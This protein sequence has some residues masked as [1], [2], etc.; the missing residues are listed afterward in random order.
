[1]QNIFKNS[2]L[3]PNEIYDLFYD[4]I[5]L[6]RQNYLFLHKKADKYCSQ[7]IPKYPDPDDFRSGFFILADKEIIIDCELL[8]YYSDSFKKETFYK[9]HPPLH[10]DFG[11]RVDSCIEKIM[12]L[13]KSSL[14]RLMSIMEYSVREIILNSESELAT[15]V[16]RRDKLCDSFDNVYSKLE[17]DEQKPWKKFKQEV[18]SLPPFDSIAKIAEK[19]FSLGLIKKESFEIWKVL[20]TLRNSIVHNNA[21]LDTKLNS[22]KISKLVDKE[23][24]NF[25]QLELILEPGQGIQTDGFSSLLLLIFL[26]LDLFKE[27]L[28]NFEKMSKKL[29]VS[30]LNQDTVDN[31]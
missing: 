6:T 8:A 19:S 2:K 22:Q 18:K 9:A 25:Q 29:E 10:C 12:T 26:G 30:I 23:I 1:M 17:S 28:T 24:N 21:I 4:E 16:N 27:W 15:C 20:I 13:Q 3:Q 7:F 11:D 14:V 31:C 5:L